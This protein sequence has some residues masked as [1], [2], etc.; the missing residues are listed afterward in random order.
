MSPPKPSSLS[1]AVL[2][3]FIFALT[4]LLANAASAPLP[5]PAPARTSGETFPEISLE[6]PRSGVAPP[7]IEGPR[8]ALSVREAVSIA[9]ARSFDV[10]IAGFSP[11]LA[12]NEITK[13]ESVFDPAAVA[14]VSASKSSLETASRLVAAGDRRETETQSLSGG[15]RQRLVTGAEYSLIFEGIKESTNSLQNSFDPTFQTGLTFTIRQPLL[16]NFGVDFNR[17]KIRVAAAAKEQTLH[18]YRKQVI[19]TVDAVEQAYWN[20]VFS[21]E[22]LQFR[23]KSLDL[24]KDLLRRNRIQVEV[25]TLAPIEITEAEATVASREEALLVAEREVKDREDALKMLLNVTDKPFS[26]G[27]SILPT[28]KPAFRAVKLDEMH[29]TL[30]ALSKHADLESARIEIEKKKIDLKTAK[31]NLLP[32]LDLNASASSNS[33]ARKGTKAL[34]ERFGDDGYTVS[35]GVSF[36]VPLGNRQAKASYRQAQLRHAQTVASY[37]QKRQTVMEAVRRG[38]RRVRVDVKRIEATRVARR[39]AEE[40]LDAQEKKFKV[41]LWTSRDILEDQEGLANALTQETRALIDYHKSLAS[42]D[43][44]THS[45]LE[46]FQIEM[47]RPGDARTKPAPR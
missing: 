40:R 34:E 14:D 46:R 19:E 18:A 17:A 4:P 29:L 27:I 10:T 24:A 13:E 2:L 45:T 11:D 43:R 31:Q 30:K 33:L 15:I 37:H 32:Q 41:G 35:G 36:R 26:W 44:A 16:R 47:A 39:L 1:F 12:E 8:L 3:I 23:R 25:G 38:A 5:F 21:I 7:S 28:D 22:N 20:L 9:L 42:L 6:R